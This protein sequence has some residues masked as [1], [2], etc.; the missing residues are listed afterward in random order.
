M[1]KIIA[2]SL[3][4]NNPKYNMGAIENAKIAQ[5]LYKDWLCKFYIGQSVP[6]LT[7]KELKKLDNTD[8]IIMDQAG[9]WSGMF[10]RFLPAFDESVDIMVSR[11]TDSRLSE[12]EKQ[13]VDEWLLS[14]K[15]FHIM[16]DHPFHNTQ[17]LGGMWG[18]RNNLL[19]KLSIDMAGFVKDNFWQV[20]QNFLRS[21]VY[22]FVVDHSMIHDNYR[23]YNEPNAKNFPTNR[24]NKE[25]VGEIYDEYNNRHPDHYTL[26]QE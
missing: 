3:W 18:V 19:N 13:A 12:R 8:V 24:I 10:W 5:N 25:F 16:R 21:C 20:D 22:P 14:D 2:F 1:L 17:I 26:I 4:G 11:D 23:A 9:D 15:D 6:S 7:I